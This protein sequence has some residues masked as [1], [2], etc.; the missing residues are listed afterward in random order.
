ML[1][2][3]WALHLR[4]ALVALIALTLVQSGSSCGSGT[5]LPTTPIDCIHA[6][7]DRKAARRRSAARIQ[8]AWVPYR[9]I[10]MHLK[11]AVVAA[12]DAKFF[13]HDGFDWE[14]ILKAIL[15]EHREGE[16]VSGGST[17]T[18]QL[19]KNLSFRR[20]HV[21]AQ[22]AGS[23]DHDDDRD[24]AREARILEI[25][26]NVV[27][28]GEAAF[29]AEAAARSHYGVSAADLSPEQRRVSRR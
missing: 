13:Q 2:A 12:E 8:H 25:Y 1:S 18:Q 7:A 28:W 22:G 5:S 26:L 10:S 4:I 29:G 11:R 21:V 17:I 23:G 15:E 6:R 27:E 20:S 16:V 3:L 14:G 9:R 19:A 24:R